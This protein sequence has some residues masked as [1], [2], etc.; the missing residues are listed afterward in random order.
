L[1]TRSDMS[2]RYPLRF[3]WLDAFSL[4]FHVTTYDRLDWSR[5]VLGGIGLW[6]WPCII[7]SRSL[8]LLRINHPLE[9]N[10]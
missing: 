8:R 9:I 5:L 6:G 4:F 3:R 10:Q 1:M 2:H 7:G